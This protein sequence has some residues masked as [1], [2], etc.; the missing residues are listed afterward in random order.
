VSGDEPANGTTE[1]YGSFRGAV[2][3]EPEHYNEEMLALRYAALLALI[4]WAGGLV[5]L[6]AVAAP[7]MFDVLS[8]RQVP[9]ARFLA[10]A[11]FGETLRRFHTISYVCGAA[12]V[13]S[14]T[15]RAILGPRPRRFAV[16]IAISVTM[17]AASLYS[18]LVVARQTERLRREIGVAPSSLPPDDV[19]RTAFG[20]LHGT[21]TVLEMIP[22]LGGLVLLAWELRD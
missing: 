10:G 21:A 19:R 20:R 6:G 13:C 5:A 17:L 22:L 12:L 3:D 1:Q 7:S 8:A 2:R 18:G 11:I 4:I 14:L 15:A 9:D 16:R